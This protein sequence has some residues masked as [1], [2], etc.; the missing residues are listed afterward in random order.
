MTSLSE[1][2]RA[3]RP[4]F[5][6]VRDH[7]AIDFANN[8]LDG[9]GSADRSLP[10]YVANEAGDPAFARRVSKASRFTFSVNETVLD[11]ALPV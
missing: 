8:P 7:P 9:S 2:R 3:D 1:Q 6:L 5:M 11:L 4:E 10:G